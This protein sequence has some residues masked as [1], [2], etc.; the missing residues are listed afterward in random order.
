[1]L[2]VLMH[3]NFQTV[4]QQRTGYRKPDGAPS[5]AGRASNFVL[6]F[7]FIRAV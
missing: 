7:T 3:E 1:M 5:S 6:D 4:Y 2:F